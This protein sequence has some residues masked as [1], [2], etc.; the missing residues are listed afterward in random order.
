MH[1]YCIVMKR[2]SFQDV[3]YS[4]Y[5]PERQIYD[6]ELKEIAKEMMH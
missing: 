6:D 3:L 2:G 4:P 5:D 1:R